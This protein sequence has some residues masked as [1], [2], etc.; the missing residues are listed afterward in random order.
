[1][2]KNQDILDKLW[3]RL[4]VYPQLRKFFVHKSNGK[5]DNFVDSLI[6]S[7]I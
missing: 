1:M 4:V 5:V 6:L 3:I 7:H 2:K